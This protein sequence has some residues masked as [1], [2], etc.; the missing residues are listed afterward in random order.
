[1]IFRFLSKGFLVFNFFLL[2]LYLI[3]G[4]GQSNTDR[5]TSNK[6]THYFR[7]GE[8]LYTNHCSNCHQANGT[9][10][11]RVYPPLN[12]SDFMENNFEQVL[13]LMRNGID[14]E[15]VVNGVHYNQA[16][17]GVPTLTNLEI[18]EIATYIYNAWEHQKGL[19]D[20]QSV[21]K[22]L[23]ACGAQ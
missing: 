20:V 21:D 13:C 9:G 1:M 4:C 14:G 12:K 5:N 15:L 19:I 22:I 10:L 16:M 3:Q 17:P 6:F 11:G 8:Q 23:N 7:Q 2:T 18:A